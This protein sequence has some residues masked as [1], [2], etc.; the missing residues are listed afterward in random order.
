MSAL[1]HYLKL[2]VQARLGLDYAVIAW[3]MVAAVS[4]VITFVFLILT[5]WIVLEERY[6]PLVATLTV[7][8]FFLLL[9]LTAVIACVM[10][11]RRSIRLASQEL[12]ARS[13][14]PWVQP[15]TLLVGM[16]I[17]RT[18]GWRR[19]VPLIA[20]GVIAAGVTKEWFSNDNAGRDEGADGD[21]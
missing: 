20:V 16:K 10:G 12:V 6:S 5:T 17:G 2:Q 3:A 15:N 9:A 4:S 1:V 14:A 13:N 21:E 18:I 19:L 7:G 8:A 11:H